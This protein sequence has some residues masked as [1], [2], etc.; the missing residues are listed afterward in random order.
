[1]TPDTLP[2]I[3]ALAGQSDPRITAAT[4][5]DSK[6][7]PSVDPLARTF[8]GRIGDIDPKLMGMNKRG[9]GVFYTVNETDLKGRK[10][11]NFTRVRAVWQDDDVGHGWDNPLIDLN[12]VIQTSLGKS[13]GL[14]F[15]DTTLLG[16]FDAVQARLIQDHGCDPNA[17]GLYRVLRLP[18]YYHMKNPNKPFMVRI[19]GA[20]DPIRYSWDTIKTIF[21]PVPIT[22][23]L[24]QTPPGNGQLEL[25]G[26][27]YAALC[28]I[29]PDVGYKLWLRIGMALHHAAGGGQEGLSM[30][31][32]WSHG[33]A[34]Y[35]PGE[36]AIKYSTF[37]RRTN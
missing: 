6:D 16:E 27:I 31:D 3:E 7:R 23:P 11:K 22:K 32:T 1:M 24:H 25:P 14:V 13:Q 17:D 35:K 9:A 37:G 2:F 29:H 5:T 8:Y 15:T 28:H 4:F 30:W 34:K 20:I 21:P 26:R 10:I 18:G 19:V 12:A 36:C 33:G